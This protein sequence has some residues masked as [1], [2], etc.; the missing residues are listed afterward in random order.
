[1]GGWGRRG[2]R[3]R[4]GRDGGGEGRRDLPL[5][6][7]QEDAIADGV[8]SIVEQHAHVALE[9]PCDAIDGIG[10]ILDWVTL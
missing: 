7:V 2:R 8:G 1:V 4:R 5:A 3:R 9:A 6:S 10:A